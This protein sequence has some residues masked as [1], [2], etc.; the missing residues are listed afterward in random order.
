MPSS[1]EFPCPSCHTALTLDAETAGKEVT[2]P[3]CEAQ[4]FMPDLPAPQ[5]APREPRKARKPKSAT[6]PAEETQVQETLPL[7][8]NAEM[9]HED[10]RK[11]F[12]LHNSQPLLSAE[13]SPT[14]DER[15]SIPPTKEKSAE[16]EQRRLAAMAASLTYE[17]AKFEKKGMLSFGCPL[18]N[19][20]LWVDK[21]AS[22]LKL[23]CEGCG[24]DLISP[25]PELGLPAQLDDREHE[26]PTHQLPKA[27]IP[28][29][30][31]V[32]DV[33]LEEGRS[34]GR[35]KRQTP[36]P[37]QISAQTPVKLQPVQARGDDSFTGQPVQLPSERISKARTVGDRRPEMEP[38]QEPED[39]S[40][41]EPPIAPKE[42][43]R[44]KGAIR[45]NDKRRNFSPQKLIEND[46]EVD[47]FWGPV[48][49]KPPASRRMMI[50]GWLALIP[51]VLGLAVWGIREVFRKKESIVGVDRNDGVDGT[52][53]FYVA[54]DVLVKYF[55]SASIEEMSRYVRHPEVTLPRMKNF[56]KRIPPNDVVEKL[57]EPMEI[58][59]A[60]IDFISPIMTLRGKNP[61]IVSLEIPKVDTNDL[62]I[63][64]ESM[65]HWSEVPWD[66]FMAQ[67]MTEAHDFR[68]VM[69]PDDYP[70]EPY[71]DKK[72]WV[73]FKLY[74]PA[75]AGKDYGFCFGY[76]EV[77]SPTAISMILPLRRANEDGHVTFNAVLSLRFTPESR[78]RKNQVPQVMIEKFT[79]GW[80]L[81]ND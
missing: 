56:Y 43:K 42:S 40:L 65:V 16:E 53:A 15:S 8:L 58:Q 54:R 20:P 71:E 25:R 64:W 31:Q 9:I 1:Q 45:L 37:G 66:D 17:H 76:V 23:K 10:N 5:P 52:R 57:E 2:C 51:I 24:S 74:N 13:T 62:R 50:V 35:T 68:V 79:D 75:N 11:N 67:E 12:P 80:I 41:V 81:P 73:C 27:V 29:A 70:I 3:H 22:G 55:A 38:P 14:L 44:D 34:G 33:R 6:K 72:R 78:G 36:V 47:A 63:D 26:V 4:V 28:K 77:N 30:R 60:D 61:Q 49:S 39:D 32:E 46:V 59:V 69:Q 19:R 18:C 48:E 21:R 7:E